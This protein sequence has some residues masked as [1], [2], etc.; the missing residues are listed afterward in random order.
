MKR[1]SRSPNV[2]CIACPAMG[3][4]WGSG[5]PTLRYTLAIASAASSSDLT[6]TPRFSAQCAMRSASNMW[7]GNPYTS[8]MY[9]ATRKASAYTLYAV[10]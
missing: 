1:A 7:R 3:S 10:R 5:I 4:V 8:P 9:P 2:R 6:N